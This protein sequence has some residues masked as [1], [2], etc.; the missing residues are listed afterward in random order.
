[1]HM[2]D[3]GMDPD[4][5]YGS[6]YLTNSTGLVDTESDQV[7]KELFGCKFSLHGFSLMLNEGSIHLLSIMLVLMLS[8][9]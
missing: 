6:I 1:M 2:V 5:A 7:V 9:N 4:D 8:K 3:E